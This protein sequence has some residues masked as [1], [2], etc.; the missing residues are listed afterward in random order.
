MDISNPT[1]IVTHYIEQ[2]DQPIQ[3]EVCL[4]SFIENEGNFRHSENLVKNDIEYQFVQKC[5]TD[6]L[7]SCLEVTEITRFER[8][9]QIEKFLNNLKEIIEKCPSKPLFETIK[10]LW[11]G[12]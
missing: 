6:G 12:T 11:F 9:D 5:F 7:E 4:L 3:Q 10:L 1:K 8:F 2:S